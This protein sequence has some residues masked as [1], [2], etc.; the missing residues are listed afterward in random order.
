[1]TEASKKLNIRKCEQNE[2]FRYI[3]LYLIYYK[4]ALK[5]LN[6]IDKHEPTTL[7]EVAKR[8]NTSEST[9][10]RQCAKLAKMHAIKI[11]PHG[12]NKQITITLSGK[13]LLMV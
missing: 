9:I 10:S 4:K 13:M 1:M 6:D 5:I 12:R 7:I 8:I 11:T 2:H 3:K